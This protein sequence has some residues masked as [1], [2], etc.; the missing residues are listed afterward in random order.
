MRHLFWGQQNSRAVSPGLV[1]A[2]VICHLLGLQTPGAQA[3]PPRTDWGLPENVR[4]RE[5]SLPG[6]LCGDRSLSGFSSCLMGQ[7]GHCPSAAVGPPKD[8]GV[9]G[10]RQ[11]TEQAGMSGWGLLQVDPL[12]LLRAWFWVPGWLRWFK[13]PT[14]AQVVISWFVSSRPA[15]GLRAGAA[16]DSVSP[17]LPGPPPLTLSL[18]N[19]QKRVWLQG[20]RA[21]ETGSWGSPGIGQGQSWERSCPLRAWGHKEV[22]RARHV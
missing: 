2:S 13:C 6:L 11:L 8:T 16:S 21:Q 20:L 22:V 12:S 4:E 15:S 14:S 9:K 17:S 7:V 5:L 10:S 3:S 18:K 19:K 1:A